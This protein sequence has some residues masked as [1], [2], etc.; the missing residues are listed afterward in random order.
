MSALA[1]LPKPRIPRKLI[2]EGLATSVANLR[3]LCF[4]TAEVGT[5]VSAQMEAVLPFR[6]E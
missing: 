1:C 3:D 2:D 6:T 4:D 5:C